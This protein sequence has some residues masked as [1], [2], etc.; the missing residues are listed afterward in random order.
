MYTDINT[1]P[2][3]REIDYENCCGQIHDNITLVQTA[4][5]LMRSRYTA[6]TKGMG[7]YLMKSHHSSTRPISEKEDIE[8]WAKSVEWDHLE[9]I[10]KSDGEL[11]N[12]IGVV[13]FKAFFYSSPIG[14]GVKKRECIH[15][16]SEFVREH[17]H[18]VYINA[19]NFN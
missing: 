4:E 10:S 12:N 1:C 13:E 2:C 7:D 9:I 17:G 11:L 16:K 15:E 18:W 8:K 5:Q 3:G 19:L 6:F 14:A